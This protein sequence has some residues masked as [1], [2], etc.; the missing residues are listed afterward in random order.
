MDNSPT[1]LIP[2]INSILSDNENQSHSIYHGY[3][4]TNPQLTTKDGKIIKGE[5]G[6]VFNINSKG[7]ATYYPSPQVYND[8]SGKRGV[9]GSGNY[10]ADSPSIPTTSYLINPNVTGYDEKA[11]VYV[12]RTIRPG[13]SQGD[14]AKNIF[15]GVK[16]PIQFDYKGCST[17]PKDNKYVLSTP[18]NKINIIS[19]SYG[20]NCGNATGNRTQVVKDYISNHPNQSSYDISRQVINFQ[21]PYPGCNKQISIDYECDGVKQTV[22]RKDGLFDSGYPVTIKCNSSESSL[23]KCYYDALAKGFSYFGLANTDNTSNLGTCYAGGSDIL[24]NQW[25]N[26]GTP[27][28]SINV[29]KDFG[30]QGHSI[31]HFFLGRNN[32]AYFSEN[33]IHAE[34]NLTFYDLCKKGKLANANT[35]NCNTFNSAWND[36]TRA[37][38][39][40]NGNL[41]F[42]SFP[43]GTNLPSDLRQNPQNYSNRMLYSSGTQGAPLHVGWTDKDISTGVQDNMLIATPNILGNLMAGQ[44]I[45]SLDG[46]LKLTF[47]DDYTL[48]LYTGDPTASGCKKS[49]SNEWLGS[50]G[51]AINQINPSK[52]GGDDYLGKTAYVN[53]LGEAHEYTDPSLLHYSDKYTTNPGYTLKDIDTND[54]ATKFNDT[55]GFIYDTTTASISRCQ[56]QCSKS[57]TCVG[58]VIDN[59]SCYLL[60]SI[61]NNDVTYKDSVKGGGYNTYP[62]S[63]IN[64]YD[65]ASS[66]QASKPEDCFSYCDKINGCVGVEYWTSSGQCFPKNKDGPAHK[67]SAGSNNTVYLKN[68][69]QAQPVTTLRIPS[70][71]KETTPT[72]TIYPNYALPGADLGPTTTN[73]ANECLDICN[74][75]DNCHSVEYNRNGTCYPKTYKETT[76]MY[77]S[78]NVDVYM[79]NPTSNAN[80]MET[81]YTTHEHS[82]INGYDLGNPKEKTP[83]AQ[84]CMNACSKRSD[85]A[86]VEFWDWNGACFLKSKAAVPHLAKTTGNNRIFVKN[87]FPAG[88]SYLVP[89]DINVVNPNKYANYNISPITMTNTTH[90]VDLMPSSITQNF[91]QTNDK[92][93]D[94]NNKIVDET[95]RIIRESFTSTQQ[96]M[97]NDKNL[98]K[99]DDK[100]A[101]YMKGNP[102]LLTN[103][104]TLNKMVSNSSIQMRYLNILYSVLFILTCILL[105]VTFTISL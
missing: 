52:M 81:T 92:L 75:N 77:P 33:G 74:K 31:T 100:L 19:A 40:A 18:S 79:R 42:F 17:V 78:N 62:S 99:L 70:I 80:V 13:Q 68:M 64:G 93:K 7:V 2:K 45:Y 1:T 101:N 32:N 49:L 11:K 36:D 25:Q 41:Y 69:G 53:R 83:K 61:N 54:S 48:V 22:S 24:N 105:V 67:A 82:W 56:T 47:N 27:I 12:N 98:S 51:I 34:G 35:A 58:T 15:A 37:M 43:A 26:P 29:Q 72:Y 5:D 16:T 103:L 4:E 23:T 59:N 102:T 88:T 76:T 96:Y 66:I 44:S 73:T 95:D 21:D 30:Y 10:T 57:G 6:R 55:S 50:G 28:W 65:I 71:N 38:F 39:L 90:D 3:N 9:G 63:W 84:D 20:S 85:C 97:M 87:T 86:V 60:S 89:E 104:V 8:T 91:F 94:V 46:K 14:E